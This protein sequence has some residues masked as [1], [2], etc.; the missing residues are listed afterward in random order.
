MNHRSLRKGVT[1]IELMLYVLLS[2]IVVTSIFY[3]FNNSNNIFVSQTSKIRTVETAR[4]AV[5]FLSNSIKKTGWKNFMKPISATE[6]E[7]PIN[8][9]ASYVDNP[10]GDKDESSF[11]FFEQG[12]N[13]LSSTSD[14]LTIRYLIIDPETGKAVDEHGDT[15]T[16]LSKSVVAEESYYLGLKGHEND[17][18]IHKKL[19]NS[20]GTV[21]DYKEQILVP[22]IAAFQAEFGLLGVKQ[23]IIEG[24]S[25]IPS[26]ITTNTSSNSINADTIMATSNNTTFSISMDIFKDH[27]SFRLVKGSQYSIRFKLTADDSSID[28]WND[29]SLVV[30]VMSSDGA[31]SEDIAKINSTG[32]QFLTYSVSSNAGNDFIDKASLKFSF[33]TRIGSKIK[34]SNLTVVKESKSTIT[35]VGDEV[36]KDIWREADFRSDYGI[37][38]SGT[39]DNWIENKKNVRAIRISI[40]AKSTSAKRGVNSSSDKYSLG[41]MNDYRPYIDSRGK[42]Y[43]YRTYRV[44]IPVTQNGKFTTK[45]GA[46]T[47]YASAPTATNADTDGDGV[48][49]SDDNCPNIANANQADSNG[50]GIGD[51]CDKPVDSDNDGIADSDDNCPHIANANQ[52]DDDGDG[53]GNSCDSDYGETTEDPNDTD[54]DGIAN[55]SDNCPSVANA[56]QADFDGDGI[57]DVCDEDSDAKY[58]LVLSTEGNG[59]ITGTAAAEYETGTAISLGVDYD[60]NVTSFD[61]WE[62]GPQNGLT[63][64]NYS[65]KING[66]TH[67]T[68]V[69]QDKAVI[70]AIIA[71]GSGE[72]SAAEGDGWFTDS[73]E[74]V[75]SDGATAVV[76]AKAAMGSVFTGWTDNYNSTAIISLDNNYEFVADGKSDVFAHFAPGYNI[77]NRVKSNRADITVNISNF[78]DKLMAFNDTIGVVDGSTITITISPKSGYEFKKWTNDLSTEGSSLSFTTT[79]H[80]DINIKAWVAGLIAYWDMQSSVDDKTGEG[81]N[82]TMDANSPGYISSSCNNTALN[83]VATSNQYLDV[84]DFNIEGDELTVSAWIKANS[85]PNGQPRVISKG[86]STSHQDWA[87]VVDDVDSKTYLANIQFRVN[88]G[89]ANVSTHVGQT[90]DPG[91][92]YHIVGVYDGSNIYTYVD[93]VKGSNN[94]NKNG[95]ISNDNDRVWIGGQ[96]TNSSDRPWDGMIDE[97]K[98]YNKALTDAEVLDLYNSFKSGKAWCGFDYIKRYYSMNAISTVVKDS[99][100]NSDA[101]VYGNPT[102]SPEGC[103]NS[104]N[105]DGNGDYLKTDDINLYDDQLTI[106]SWV[107]NNN[108]NSILNLSPRILSKGHNDNNEIWSL[109]FESSL[110]GENKATLKLKT[111]NNSQISI[112]SSDTLK[113][114]TWY[115]ITGTYDGSS[116][117]LYINDQLISTYSISGLID[118]STSLTNVENVSIGATPDGNH[119]WNGLLDNV[120]ILN[121]AYSASDISSYYNSTKS[122]HTN[123][124]NNLPVINSFRISPN[125]GYGS[126]TDVE[127]SSTATD[128]DGDPLTYTWD[129]NDGS[130][131]YSEEG[132]TLS[133][134]DFNNEGTFTVTLTVSDGK[135]SVTQ[136]GTVIVGAQYQLYFSFTGTGTDNVVNI[137]GNDYTGSNGTA[138]TITF[139]EGTDVNLSAT[140][141]GGDNFVQWEGDLTGS[142]NPTTI[143][144]D[145]DKTL[146]ANFDKP[147]YTLTVAT[148][149]DGTVTVEKDGNTVSSPYTYPAGTVL[150]LTANDGADTFDGWSGDLS[151]TNNPE[152][153][154]LTA[155]KSVTATFT[156]SNICN[157][158]VVFPNDTN[159]IIDVGDCGQYTKIKSDYNSDLKIGN[160]GSSN[161]VFDIYDDNMN[162]LMSNANVPNSGWSSFS[163]GTQQ[164][165]LRC[166][167]KSSSNGTSAKFKFSD[168]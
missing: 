112:S 13:G 11:D 72:V 138:Q 96:S 73:A 120:F 121:K 110:L 16:V 166:H 90:L 131:T 35:W 36:G 58:D 103:D 105:F 3:A 56:D 47:S 67:I 101:I 93:G 97:V 15:T 81:N 115:L 130:N 164:E 159:K 109:S 21:T 76:K 8:R 28:V 154:T 41:N 34:I 167:L 6:F 4:E 46:D 30:S 65:F 25:P 91:M 132:S 153:I 80:S 52:A 89:S 122:C 151:G 157:N 40:L 117:K 160:W 19:I 111:Y 31:F 107:K 139:G 18:M 94:Y 84:G 23:P 88:T 141:N 137:D 116:A 99:V 74:W 145:G 85:F 68:A 42:H 75:Y 5:N 125:S 148:S 10:S 24:T 2:S 38:G 82:G 95:D 168:W 150:Q 39:K 133:G 66:Y 129:W 108:D 104:I 20:S 155:N 83:F 70:T 140:A 136:S 29:S 144:M 60:S 78:G 33:D 142:T 92:W 57:G 126:V 63:G 135:G 86:S 55:A 62:G 156:S 124:P 17:L 79:V 14:K 12:T 44:V 161:L 163:V 64:E 143:T 119:F 71:E 54:G 9:L 49:D 165:T 113:T 100:N 37:V 102:I 26:V 134:K 128:A 27:N 158:T 149:G 43:T 50:D 87:L 48:L 106:S 1:L 114:D 146:R 127:F 69:F 32:D 162:L 61:H 118:Y 77:V 147:N 123:V 98:V 53:I 59:S 45:T 152:T 7:Y 22:N 51:A